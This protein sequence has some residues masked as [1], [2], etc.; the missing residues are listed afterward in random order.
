MNGISTFF[1]F[2][3]DP[4]MSPGP[5]CLERNVKNV[6]A[7]ALVIEISEN[8]NYW[9]LNLVA[10]ESWKGRRHC[11]KESRIK[12]DAKLFT[13]HFSMHH[14]WFSFLKNKSCRSDILIMDFSHKCRSRF[15]DHCYHI[16]M[17]QI[18]KE[19][20]WEYKR[21]KNCLWK[22]TYQNL[23][24]IAQCRATDVPRHPGMLWEC[25]RCHVTFL[26]Y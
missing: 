20:F 7:M 1:Y 11:I 9:S 22:L 18:R 26:K 17:I 4:S 2:F 25:L 24:P 16:T 5:C 13:S 19:G 6:Y 3:F 23:I 8:V 10:N 14:S 12:N 15:G 21:I